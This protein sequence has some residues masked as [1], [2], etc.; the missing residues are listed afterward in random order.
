[1]VWK[2]EFLFTKLLNDNN[3]LYEAEVVGKH[4]GSHQELTVHSINNSTVARNQISKI[5]RIH[6]SV[7]WNKPYP[8][9]F[10]DH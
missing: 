5:L 10:G 4:K 2:Y 3:S 8:R 7:D 6:C 1:M 9:K